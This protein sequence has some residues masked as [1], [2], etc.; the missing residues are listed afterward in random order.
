TTNVSQSG[1]IASSRLTVGDMAYETNPAI[2]RWVNWYTQTTGGRRTMTIGIERSDAYLRMARSE[3]RKIGL[4]ED[5]VWL[6]HVESVWNP[7]AVS[8]AAAGGLW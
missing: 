7:N 5:L 1:K 4:P 8:P 3:F 6:A 2:D